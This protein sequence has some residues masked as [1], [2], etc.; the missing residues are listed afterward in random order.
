MTPEEQTAAWQRI[1]K[2]N[3]EDKQQAELKLPEMREKYLN[4]RVGY[5]GTYENQLVGFEPLYGT[6]VDIRVWNYGS[7]MNAEFVYALQVEIDP[8]IEIKNTIFGRKSAVFVGG[9]A[10]HEVWL[11]N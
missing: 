7:T 2:R 3:E 6:V 5:N 9:S 10:H 11:D 1:L 4:K 8:S